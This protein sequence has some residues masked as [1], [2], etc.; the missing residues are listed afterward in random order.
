MEEGRD[1][2][3]QELESLDFL[4][5]AEGHLQASEARGVACSNLTFRNIYNV[6]TKE[7]RQR[8]RR[9]AL[10]QHPTRKKNQEKQQSWEI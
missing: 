10:A 7:W 2:I 8:A 6:E 5:L 9:Q 4:L 3:I 1:Y